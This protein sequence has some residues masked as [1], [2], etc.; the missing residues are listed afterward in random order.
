MQVRWFSS[1]TR[2]RRVT[3]VLDEMIRERGRPHC[4]RCDDGPELTSRHFLSWCMENRIELCHIQPGKPTQNGYVESFHGKLRDEFLNVSW[5]LN[6]FDARRKIKEWRRDYNEQ[7]P[8]SAL[9]YLT[10]AAFAPQS[11]A[12]SFAFL[13]ECVAGEGPVKASLRRKGTALTGPF[14]RERNP[15]TEMRAKEDFGLRGAT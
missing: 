6:L 1:G 7:R 12:S 4:I 8:H 13:P 3:R 5:F 10:P 15:I 2:Q 11:A 9:G 14:S